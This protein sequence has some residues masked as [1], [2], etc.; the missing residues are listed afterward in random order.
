MRPGRTV[1]RA[2]ADNDRFI[3]LPWKAQGY[4]RASAHTYRVEL[5][6]EDERRMKIGWDFS[7]GGHS[8]RPILHAEASWTIYGSGD[9]LF[10]AHARVREGIPFLPR[11]GLR[12][13]MPEG[14]EG[15]EYF[16]YGPHE[17]YIDKRRS[18]WKSRFS[19]TV[20][21]MHED[22]LRPQENGSHYDT[23]WAAITGERGAGFSSSGRRVS[24]SMRPTSRRRS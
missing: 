6:E 22:Y 8:R 20:D 10:H 17:S 23:E 19:S 9:I 13:V 15:V 11:F 7:L 4:D 16:G 14:S 18:T 3:T 2:P 21:G 12:L 1:Y 24:P 5:L